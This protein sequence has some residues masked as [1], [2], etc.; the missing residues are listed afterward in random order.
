M[1]VRARRAS[2]GTSPRAGACGSDPATNPQGRVCHNTRE[3][4]TRAGSH[5]LIY[6]SPA[7]AAQWGTSQLS[8][9]EP[10]ARLVACGSLVM[11][12]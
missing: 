4:R 2:G 8:A 1:L 5:H 6:P 7:L 12:T 3:R 11:V 10:R 9:C